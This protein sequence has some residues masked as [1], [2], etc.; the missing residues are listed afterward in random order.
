MGGGLHK[1][2]P[3]TSSSTSQAP[4][5]PARAECKQL[6]HGRQVKSSQEQSS[7][8]ASAPK[9]TTTKFTTNNPR[10]TS[11][12][13]RPDRDSSPPPPKL[14]DAADS[15]PPANKKKTSNKHQ[16]RSAHPTTTTTTAHHASGYAPRGRVR[17]RPVQGEM[18]CL[19]SCATEAVISG[20]LLSTM[21]VRFEADET[22]R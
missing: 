18:K 2:H 17:R 22:T 8:I 12:E 10:T 16:D 1:R 15:T 5:N 19:S 11:P 3:S 6:L 21:A 20:P 7:R 14:T 4:A 9:P 13:R